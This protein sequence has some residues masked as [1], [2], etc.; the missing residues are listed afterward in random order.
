M[1]STYQED[2][3]DKGRKY[4]YQPLGYPRRHLRHYLI[5]QSKAVLEQSFH[6]HERI[7][8]TKT[9]HRH[10][11]SSPNQ[12]KN[13]TIQPNAF[14]VASTLCRRLPWRLGPDC[15]TAYICIHLP[16]KS[17][18]E[19]YLFFVDTLLPSPWS[20]NNWKSVCLSIRRLWSDSC[21][22]TAHTASWKAGND[23][24]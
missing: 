19:Y 14:T 4:L 13:L 15:H 5:W 16:N 7:S 2:H 20:D 24:E 21:T 9:G 11:I 17:M 18:N 10:C 12:W 3:V 23:E 6:L 8:K 22:S 1:S